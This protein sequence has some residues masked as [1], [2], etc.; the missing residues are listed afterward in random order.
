MKALI[1]ILFQFFLCFKSIDNIVAYLKVFVVSSLFLVKLFVFEIKNVWHC[2]SMTHHTNTPV[3]HRMIDSQTYLFGCLD[4]GKNFHTVWLV[5]TTL[6][7]NGINC[8]PI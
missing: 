1:I 2:L 3:I 7:L 8:F 4:F 5:N 6:Q